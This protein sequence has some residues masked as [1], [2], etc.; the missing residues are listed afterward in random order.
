M[1][2]GTRLEK[3]RQ[4]ELR[5]ATAQQM[6]IAQIDADI[7]EKTLDALENV[8]ASAAREILSK[9]EDLKRLVLGGD[10]NPVVCFHVLHALFIVLAFREIN[11]KEFLNSMSDENISVLRELITVAKTRIRPVPET[12]NELIQKRKEKRLLPNTREYIATQAMISSA[13]LSISVEKYWEDAVRELE[14]WL[15]EIDNFKREEQ[16][17]KDDDSL[18]TWWTMKELAEKLACKDV[19]AFYRGKCELLKQKP[20]LAAEI[21]SWFG[22]KGVK[23]LFNPKCFAELKT[24]WNEIILQPKTKVNQGRRTRKTSAT[25]KASVKKAAR[26]KSENVVTAP[27]AQIVQN[28]QTPKAK[29]GRKPKKAKVEVQAETPKDDKELK[30]LVDV[31]AFKTLLTGLQKIRDEALKDLEAKEKSYQTL[32]SEV[33]AAEDPDKRTDLLNDVSAANEAVKKA[34]N[35]YESLAEQLKKGSELLLQQQ[36]IEKELK[37]ITAKIKKFVDENSEIVK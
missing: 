37:Q 27:T 10:K 15:N 17:S 13:R 19:D 34:K 24:L 25:P 18:Q 7:I 2:L 33:L 11:H 9:P 29:R 21:N 1:Q 8:K 6:S 22:Q 26:K 30:T 32:A 20:L 28:T 31:K 36:A 12:L 3:K 23:K 4:K 14:I 35:E 5:N 16:V